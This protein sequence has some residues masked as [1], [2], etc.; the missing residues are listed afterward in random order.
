MPWQPPDHWTEVQSQLKKTGQVKLDA[1]GNG[2]LYF[3]PDSARQR[4]QVSSVIV[5]TSQAANA[6]V[7]P[8]AQVAL[9]TTDLGTMS[10]GNNRGATWSGNQ[11]TFQGNI[12]VGPVD[13]L[14]VLFNP[15][16]GSTAGQIAQLVGVIA[17]VVVLGDKFTRRA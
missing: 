6:T 11:D 16:P 14:T 8:Q 15:A 7:V 4:W 17:S 2:V 1:S 12:D 9:N 10:Q 3:T 13:Y 5:T